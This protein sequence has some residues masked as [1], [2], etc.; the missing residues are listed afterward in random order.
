MNSIQM[1]QFFVQWLNQILRDEH[2]RRA[3][4]ARAQERELPVIELGEQSDATE[5]RVTFENCTAT[6]V[7][8]P[9]EGMVNA[10]ERLL[11]EVRR[12]SR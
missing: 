8:K 3:L 6:V 1:Q 10:V 5:L 7:G 9:G 2:A 4:V 11:E 12:Q